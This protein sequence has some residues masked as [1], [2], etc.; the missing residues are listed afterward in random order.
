MTREIHCRGCHRQASDLEGKRE[1]TRFKK[2]VWTISEKMLV[3]QK[4]AFERELTHEAW[5]QK[6]VQ[7]IEMYVDPSAHPKR[8]VCR[9]L[10]KTSL[11]AG[12]HVYD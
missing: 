4:Y 3:T 9:N 12:L 10:V 1:K 6:E 2:W 11:F 7:E 5:T 8:S